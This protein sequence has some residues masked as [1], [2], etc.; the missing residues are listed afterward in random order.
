MPDI[1]NLPS[2]LLA[3]EPA[4]PE[5]VL[6]VLRD[7]H[8]QEF[9]CDQGSRL[10]A[11]LNF[12]TTVREWLDE[13]D[14][15]GWRDLA[16]VLSREWSIDCS[17]AGWRGVLKPTRSRKLSDVCDFIARR[18]MRPR[19]RSAGFLGAQCVAAGAFLTVRSL[20][21]RAGEDA[22]AIA[23]ST[24]LAEYARRRSH[25]FLGPISRLSPGSLPLVRIEPGCIYRW[26]LWAQLPGVIGLVVGSF[27]DLPLLTIGGAA[28][29]VPAWLTSWLAAAYLL[30]RKVELTGLKTFRDLA[31]AIANGDLV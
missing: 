16:A 12:D 7:E 24:P 15:F 4:T 2:D 31:V 8:H 6:A 11:E 3:E 22:D 23:P 14:F 19:I 26:A 18:A 21:A 30:P 25:L 20:L 5:Y 29:L 28:V 17:D 9:K 1:C 27:A 10:D 13:Y